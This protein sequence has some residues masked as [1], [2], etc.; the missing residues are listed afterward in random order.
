MV[1]RAG[2]VESWEGRAPKNWCLQTVMLEKTPESLLGSK[3]IKLVILKKNQL[4]ILVWRTYAEAE[5]PVFWST[6][7]NSQLTGK[8]PDAR[9]DWGQK[10]QRASGDKMDGWH[11]W[12]NG[13][14]LGQT[15]GDG[16]GQGDLVCCSPWGRKESNTTV[17]LNNNVRMSEMEQV[18]HIWWTFLI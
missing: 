1:V 17:W 12:C 7:V 10:E 14:E 9:K 15:P 16:E 13:H 18:G 5:D 2:K 6:D 11:H 3:E 8:V 4:W